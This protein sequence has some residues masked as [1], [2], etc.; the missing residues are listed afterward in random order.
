MNEVLSEAIKDL[1]KRFGEQTVLRMSDAPPELFEVQ[2]RPSGV[3]QL[4]LALGAGGIPRGRTIEIYG[5]ESSGKTTLALIMGA[6][7][8]A[9]DPECHIDSLI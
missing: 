8:Q 6:A 3:L 2:I 9:Q 1:N 5:P 7:F 4:D